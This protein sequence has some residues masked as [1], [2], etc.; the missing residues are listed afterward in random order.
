[1]TLIRVEILSNFQLNLKLNFKSIEEVRKIRES[2]RMVMRK[3]CTILNFNKHFK[4]YR[5]LH[6]RPQN[7]T[8]SIKNYVVLKYQLMNKLRTRI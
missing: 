2:Q 8:L 4:G 3:N 1:M 6:V 7:D 5:F